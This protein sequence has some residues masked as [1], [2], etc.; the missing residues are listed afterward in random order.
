[1]C[2]AT[3][4]SK[5][6]QISLD[7]CIPS[8]PSPFGTRS[9]DPLFHSGNLVQRPRLHLHSSGRGAA[10]YTG[11]VVGITDGDTLKVMHAGEPQRVR[12]WGIDCAESRQAF[13]TRAKQFTSQLAFGRQVKVVARDIDRYDRTV[14]EV[15]LPDGRS[16]NHE[17]VRA[18]LAWWYRQYA[19]NDRT[20]ENLEREAR[21][22]K[23]GL[24]VEAD[25]TPARSDILTIRHLGRSMP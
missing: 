11:K 5:N 6:A 3:S 18:G 16:L 20:L 4:G 13:G 22:A 1:V 7:A 17:L 2:P 24:W 12:L 9:G 8:S 15:I 25:P 14:G 19:A 10:S 23:R 21:A